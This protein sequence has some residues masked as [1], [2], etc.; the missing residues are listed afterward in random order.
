MLEKSLKLGS[1]ISKK[2]LYLFQES[3]FKK[4]LILKGFSVLKI[5]KFLSRRFGI[6]WTWC[7]RK[8]WGCFRC[9]CFCSIVIIKSLESVYSEI[10]K[11]DTYGYNLNIFCQKSNLYTLLL[12]N[13]LSS[14]FN[15]LI[16]KSWR[17]S[18]L[19]LK[20]TYFGNFQRKN[21]L[22]TEA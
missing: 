17:Q 14:L 8:V 2:L 4:Y 1:H 13:T 19:F 5:F 20:N 22:K 15:E 11:K 12:K 6:S 18:K 21:L 3:F 7:W 9:W 16:F 10:N